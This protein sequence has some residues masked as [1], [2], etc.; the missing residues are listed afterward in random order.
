MCFPEDL[1]DTPFTLKNLKNLPATLDF[2]SADEKT[3]K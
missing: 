2:V 3:R 1:E